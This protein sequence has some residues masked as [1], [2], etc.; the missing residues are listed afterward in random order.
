MTLCKGNCEYKT[1]NTEDERIVC[2]CNLNKKEKNESKNTD[3]NYFLEEEDDNNF[4]S[5]ILDNL[6]YKIFKCYHLLLSIDNLIT[7]PA[8]Y[9]ILIIFI[10]TLFFSLK[11]IFTGFTKLK[12]IKEKEFPTESKLTKLAMQYLNKIKN[13][14]NVEFP[15]H[16]PKQVREEEE[17]EK[18]D[19]DNKKK[20]RKTFKKSKKRI[21]VAENELISFSFLKSDFVK[22]STKNSINFVQSNKSKNKKRHTVKKNFSYKTLNFLK[23]E[24]EAIKNGKKKRGNISDD[25]DSLNK[26]PYTKAIKE[27]KRDIYQ[28]FKSFI[29]E[30]I[31]LLNLIKAEETFKEILINQYILT[32]LLDFFFN[33]LLYSDEVV[34]HKYH[35]NGK[36]DYIVTLIISLISNIITAIITYYLEYSDLL[37]ERLEQILEIK[38]KDGYLYAFN[39]FVKNI[40]IKLFFFIIIEIIIIF[41]SFYYV[42]IFSIIYSQSRVSLLINFI[43]SLFEGLLKNIIIIVLIVITRKIGINFRNKYIF[44]T[45]KYIDDNF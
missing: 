4:F 41:C 11:Y 10:I 26:S 12:K 22:R 19:L 28:I 15:S 16:P 29:F 18:E 32:L 17:E 45:S 13:D 14:D 30:K 36:L 38:I 20:K 21:S 7:N 35:N 27:D 2:E 31:D 5:Y 44:N 39:K 23:I 33:T 3:E 37:D 9:I 34:S 24:E 43:T 8:F 40:K 25:K 6:N 42:V 1:V